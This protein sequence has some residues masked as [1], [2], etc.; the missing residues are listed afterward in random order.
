MVEISVSQHNFAHVSVEVRPLEIKSVS[1][2]GGIA[3]RT[4][5]YIE[6]V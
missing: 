6:K 3:D 2:K 4:S 1:S 5:E